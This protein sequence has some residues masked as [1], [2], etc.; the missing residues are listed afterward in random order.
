M[1]LV[2]SGCSEEKHETIPAK[3]H[4]WGEW[5]VVEESTETKEG[6]EQ[7]TCGV[8]DKVEQRMMPKIVP[9]SDNTM[10]YIAVGLAA[11]SSYWL[12]S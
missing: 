8:C 9:A 5:K 2:C 11:A 10:L 1:I 4:T 12:S 6:L 3:G 7:R